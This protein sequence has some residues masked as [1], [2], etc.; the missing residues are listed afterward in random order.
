MNKSKLL[1]LAVASVCLTSFSCSSNQAKISGNFAGLADKTLYLEQ[2]SPSKSIIDSVKLTPKGEFSFR[3]KFLKN[4]PQFFNLRVGDS[5]VTLLVDKGERVKVSAFCDIT[6]SLKVEGSEGSQLIADLNRSMTLTFFDIDSLSLQLGRAE[7]EE[8]RTKLYEEITS[9]FINQKRENISFI[10]KNANSLAAIVALYQKLPNGMS[11][12]GDQK[13]FPYFKLVADSLSKIYPTSVHV[14]TLIKDVEQ[15]ENRSRIENKLSASLSDNVTSPDIEMKDM[16]N[17]SQK[18]SSL[19]GKTVMLY[20]WSTKVNN[21]SLINRELLEI[22][23]TYSPRG[24]EVYQVSLDRS[25]QDWIN[26][27][28]TQ[29]LPWINVNDFLGESSPVVSIYNIS[30]IPSNYILDREGN[31]VG[32]NLWDNSL[33]QKIEE[34]L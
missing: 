7:S 33:I 3:Y 14:R 10:V 26:A 15:F 11:I 29:K 19:R 20:F 32:K 1:H 31:I 13:D 9:K 30:S 12:F 27:I 2:L 18:L 21:S 23:N 34:T 25:K 8:E 24:F 22:Y 16:F 28:T 17:K 6:R 5:F 4:E